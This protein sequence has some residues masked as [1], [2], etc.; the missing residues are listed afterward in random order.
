MHCKVGQQYYVIRKPKLLKDFDDQSQYWKPV[1]V[2]RFGGKFA[3]TVLRE[4]NKEFEFISG[5]GEEFD[6]GYDFLECA[7]QKF[8]HAQG[9]DEF[10]PFYCFLDF[11]WSKVHGLGLSRTMTL[12]EG[13]MK[14]NHRFKQDREVQHEW[15][16]LFLKE[17]GD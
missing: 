10:L 3:H 8:Y 7:V 14:C 15:P 5:T 17:E 11:A 6:Y 13:H 4:A 9:A 12:A 1:I 16:P 2:N